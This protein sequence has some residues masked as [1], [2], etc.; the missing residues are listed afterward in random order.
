MQRPVAMPAIRSPAIL[1]N[2][3]TLRQRAVRLSQWRSSRWAA[4]DTAARHRFLAEL[5]LLRAGAHRLTAA[6]RVEQPGNPADPQIHQAMAAVWQALRG[7]TPSARPASESG[8][9]DA[10]DDFADLTSTA[11]V[12][13]DAQRSAYPDLFEADHAFD[14]K[15]A[16]RNQREKIRVE[17]TRTDRAQLRASHQEGLKRQRRAALDQLRRA[18]PS[19]FRRALQHMPIANAPVGIIDRLLQLAASD[20]A[21]QAWQLFSSNDGGT[22]IHQALLTALIT[23]AITTAAK[24]VGLLDKVNAP[25]FAQAVYGIFNAEIPLALK[26]LATTAVAAV[27]MGKRQREFEGEIDWE[28]FG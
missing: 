19:A 28:A 2:A 15:R 25:L 27:A 17:R 1:A 10:E 7:A 5:H 13:V 9:F 18:A 12:A 24:Q 3:Q 20:F 4:A 26:V 21:Q 14:P 23:S 16:R 8:H 11:P 22:P 6:V